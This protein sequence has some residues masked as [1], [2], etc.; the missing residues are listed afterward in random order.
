VPFSAGVIGAGR[1]FYEAAI[2]RGH[3]GVMAKH[4]ATAPPQVPVLFFALPRLDIR[5]TIR[6]ETSD[7]PVAWLATD[8]LRWTDAP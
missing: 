6:S 4:R 5:A 1:T 3:E 8:S 7:D 2:A